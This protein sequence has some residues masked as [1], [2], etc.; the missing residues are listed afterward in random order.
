MKAAIICDIHLPFDPDAAQYDVLRWAVSDINNKSP[1]VL[2]IAGDQTADGDISAAEKF[3]DIIGKVRCP[4]VSVIGNSDVRTNGD[5]DRIKIL[6]SPGITAV[7]GKTIFTVNTAFGYITDDDKRKLAGS[8]NGCV[9]VMHHPVN[10]LKEPDR[11]FMTEWKTSHP[12]SIIICG[13]LHKREFTAD[14]EFCVQALDPD[15]AIGEAPCVTYF[16]ICGDEILFEFSYFP[17]ERPADLYSNI[18][19]SCFNIPED[20][21][22]ALNNGIHKIELRPESVYGDPEVIK[23]ALNFFRQ[24]G[25]D[26]VSLHMPEYYYIDGNITD[27][28]RW[29]RAVDFTNKI[30]VNGV[31]M[32]VPNITVGK[33]REDTEARNKIVDFLVSSIHRLPR[34]CVV[35]IENMH[36]T[37]NEKADDNRRYGYTPEECISLVS[38]VNASVKENRAGIVL[39]VGHARNNSPYSQKYTLSTWYDMIGSYTVAYHVHQVSIDKDGIMSNH[40][41]IKDIYGPMISF[42]SFFYCWN[43]GRINHRPVFLE[44]RGGENIYNESL[45]TFLG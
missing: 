23:G 6:E 38:A 20:I 28:S 4:V 35:G 27:I 32:H 5:K 1:D 26:Y 14:R 16:D 15:K 12:K 44:L 21:Y 40:T 10:D 24:K 9:V 7:S 39:D 25:G 11:I 2:L 29:D 34:N 13:H 18:G 43:R 22:F 41:A 31:T 42:C 45:K 19:L 3:I 33:M 37:K 17:F 8:E 36:M 30:G